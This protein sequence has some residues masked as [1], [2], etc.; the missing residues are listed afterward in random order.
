MREIKRHGY[1]KSGMRK[2]GQYC[3]QLY[4]NE[5]EKLR[6]AG[7]LRPVSE[8]ILDFYELTSLE[9]YTEEMGLD[10]GVD[11]GMAVMM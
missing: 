11:F 4:Q 9:E 5:F 6:G 10:L 8:D 7:M 1:T 2:A 3:V